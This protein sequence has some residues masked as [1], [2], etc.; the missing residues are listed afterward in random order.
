MT[1]ITNIVAREIL[2]SRG[3]PTVEARVTLE[4]GAFGISSTPSGASTGEHEA[5][6]RRDGDKNRFGG[7][8]V[9][10]AV[11]SANG[12]IK[13]ALV[14]HDAEQ[15]LA[16]DTIL[17][18]L[19]GTP[20][21]TRLGAN[22]ILAVS[23]AVARAAAE[24]NHL[25]LYRYLGGVN[26]HVLPLPFFNVINGGA[27]ADNP[28]DFQEFMLVPIGAPSFSE[29]LRMGTE[30]FHTLRGILMDAGHATNVGDEGGFAPQLSKADDALQL[31]AKAVDKTVYRLGEDVAIAI[32]PAAS[33]LYDN[34]TYVLSGEGRRLSADEMIAEYETLIGRY[35]IVSIEDGMAENDWDGWKAFTA[36]VGNKVQLVGDDL[37]VTNYE[38]LAQGIKTKAGNAILVK[39]NQVGTLSETMRAVELAHRSMFSCLISHRSGETEDTTIADFAVATNAGELKTGSLSRSDRVG[40]YNRLLEIESELGS[41][42]RF[43][44]TMALRGRQA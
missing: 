13:D 2:D 37:F 43:A 8:G 32:D 20:G 34:G 38:R 30:I 28:L 31:I 35:P 6:E 33:E 21:K 26:A 3:N 41:A 17:C 1:A 11:K 27:H 10:G 42:A 5:L 24:A 12:E 25:P 7:K 39:P 36:R 40:K 9:L 23:L 16:I 4:N 44:G 15:Q 14:G 18:E 29:A 19:D 22:A